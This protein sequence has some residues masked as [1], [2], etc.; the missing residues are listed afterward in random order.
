[1]VE[2]DSQAAAERSAQ[3]IVDPRVRHFYDAERRA[4][5]AVAEILGG[6]GYI[7]WDTYL[8]FSRKDEWLESPPAPIFWMHQLIESA[9]ADKAHQHCGDDLIAQLANSMRKL[10]FIPVANVHRKT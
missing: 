8:F 5:K 9:W 1:M 2:G 4:G 10:G 7:A 3:I 6:V